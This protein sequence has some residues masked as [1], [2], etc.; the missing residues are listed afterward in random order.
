MVVEIIV[1]SATSCGGGG[2]G[3]WRG[4]GG[5]GSGANKYVVASVHVENETH[6]WLW[7][8]FIAI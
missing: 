4:G 8:L 5:G 2:G 7:E 3:G 1:C 6:I